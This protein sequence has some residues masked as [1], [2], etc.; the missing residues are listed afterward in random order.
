MLFGLFISHVYISK[1]ID[2]L[3]DLRGSIPTF[4]WLSEARVH[5]VQ[6]LDILPVEPGASYF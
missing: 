4:V 6:S 5:D 3:L 1:K 2:T